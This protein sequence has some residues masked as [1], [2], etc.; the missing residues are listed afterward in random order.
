MTGT[1]QATA[2]VTGAAVLVMAHHP[3]FNYLDVKKYILSTGDVDPNLIA[4]TRTSRQLNLFKALVMMDSTLTLTGLKGNSNQIIG[5]D[6]PLPSNMGDPN[7]NSSSLTDLNSFGREF[8]DKIKP[9]R[10]ASGKGN[11]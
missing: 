7:S 3:E 1:S 5:S 11:P 6:Q 10:E 9:T 2:F 8:V 4:K